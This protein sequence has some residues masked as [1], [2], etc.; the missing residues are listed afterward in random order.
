M[1]NALE[2]T[3]S[4]GV[5]AE[6]DK[7]YIRLYLLILKFSATPE[8]WLLFL[9]E[10]DSCDIHTNHGHYQFKH[11]HTHWKVIRRGYTLALSNSK[12]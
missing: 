10:K 8:Q 6:Q 3:P 2:T 7:Q 1:N 4:Y 5:Y 9:D 12:P 11:H